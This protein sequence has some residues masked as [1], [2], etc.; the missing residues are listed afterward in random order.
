MKKLLL[1]QE[2]AKDFRKGLFPLAILFFH[3]HPFV[4]RQIFPP[5]PP[6]S[7][8]NIPFLQSKHMQRVQLFNL[9]NKSWQSLKE[10]P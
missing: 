5:R 2:F 6:P 3:Q 7:R 4:F 10:E 1:V 8:E 9:K